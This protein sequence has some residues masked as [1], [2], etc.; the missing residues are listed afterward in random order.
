MSFF[1]CIL[2][3]SPRI[4]KCHFSEISKIGGGVM[5]RFIGRKEE[6]IALKGLTEKQSASL[7]VVTGRR[8][9]GKSRLIE[10]FGKDQHYYSFTGIPP[11]PHT[12]EQSQREVFSKQLEKNFGS[13]ATSSEDWLTL[14][15]FLAEKTEQGRVVILLDEI[16]WMGSK[17][18]DFLGKL[19][20][21]WDNHFKKNPKLILV[22]CGSISLWIEENILSST[23]FMGRISLTLKL[24]ELPL[25]DCNLFWGKEK[26][27]IS[28]YEKFKFLSVTGGIPRYLEEMKPHLSAEE[29]IRQLCFKDSGILFNEFD[30]IFSDLFSSKSETYKKIVIQLANGPNERNQIAQALGLEL[31]GVISE[32]LEDLE[33]SGFIQ[34]DFTWQFKNGE[35]SNLSLFRLS[36]NYVRFYLKWI[37]PNKKQIEANLFKQ[38]SLT[39]LPGWSSIMGLQFENLILNN[40][41]QIHR[42]LK[43]HPEEI[44]IDGP[45][46]QRS[47]VRH[48]GCQIDYLIQTKFD[49]LYVCE[50]RFSKY[51][52]KREIIDEVKTK[53]AR[54]KK[55]RNFSIRPVLIQVNGIS[56]ALEESEYFAS[57]I[58]FGQLFE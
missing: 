32:Y 51:G 30:Q 8:R 7:A 6:L 28:A 5:A 36:D 53:I 54:L 52:I 10:E 25:S 40:R 3:K 39:S 35:C 46:F 16:S 55:P 21:V 38:R 47:T 58:N 56:E 50:V 4:D 42:L 41:H 57:I 11:T 48:P 13:T 20:A 2:S 19:N 15:W 29:N 22:L 43:L 14:F 45:Y 44:I 37:L 31:G 34:R 26:K 24:S 12:T 1:G 9:I 33:K 27:L 17:D 18:S 49:S 23:G